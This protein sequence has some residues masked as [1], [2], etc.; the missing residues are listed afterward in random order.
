[1]AI[2]GKI[3]R[4]DLVFDENGRLDQLHVLDYKGTSREQSKAE[5]YIERVMS[6]LDCQLPLYAFATQQY[7]FG[8]FDTP[9][10]NSRTKAGYII[11][12]RDPVA[13][14]GKRKKALISMDEA[15][16][17]HGL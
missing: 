8:V 16:S 7:F 12:E 5:D 9:E 3:D 10:V 6:A 4:I 17:T 13:F 14:P 1:M 11:V 15:D 2:K